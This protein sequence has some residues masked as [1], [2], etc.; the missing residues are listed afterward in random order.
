MPKKIRR[1]NKKMRGRR[2][3]RRRRRGGF[4]PLRPQLGPVISA[5]G[6]GQQTKLISNN[7]TENL[8]GNVAIDISSFSTNKE[9]S[10]LQEDWELLKLRK[11][12]ITFFP[13]NKNST[14]DPIYL[15]INWDGSV[16]NFL[17]IEDNVKIIPAFR[18]GFRSYTVRFPK[19]EVAGGTNL[20][21]W[22]PFDEF[23]L[24]PTRIQLYSASVQPTQFR[25]DILMT[26]KQPIIR[27]N[28]KDGSKALK[29]GF[30][31]LLEP[32]RW[33][34]DADRTNQAKESSFLTV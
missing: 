12:V 6:R 3:I 25:V 4:N 10:Q 7:Y 18:I 13:N 34:E 33:D 23:S 5:L 30:L 19:I 24:I 15:R 21:V 20:G 29:D 28:T 1:N 8:S 26:G 14:V 32:K 31:R 2:N 17:P 27:D 9:Y 16:K 11:M 22:F